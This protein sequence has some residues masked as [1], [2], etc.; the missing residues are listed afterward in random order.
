MRVRPRTDLRP[1]LSGPDLHGRRQAW[2]GQR[3]AHHARRGQTADDRSQ[4]G[5]PASSLLSTAHPRPWEPP[6]A[7]GQDHCRHDRHDDSRERRVKRR[8]ERGAHLVGREPPPVR[9]HWDQRGRRRH[10]SGA[11][12][13][14]A[15]HQD[16]HCD[17]LRGSHGDEIS[18][19]PG[20]HLA[21]APVQG[22]RGEWAGH[23]DTRQC[24]RARLRPASTP[25]G[26]GRLRVNSPNQRHARRLTCRHRVVDK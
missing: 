16:E 10:R 21:A 2:R 5:T 20:R 7:P 25:A 11:R 14:G 24:E 17:Q 19:L 1:G 22:S 8:C 12:R 3:A 26:A 18:C 23:S 13:R 15:E 9:Q 4:R 6:V